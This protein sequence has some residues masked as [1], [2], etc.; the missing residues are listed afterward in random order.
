MHTWHSG[1]VLPL[2]V[3]V[4]CRLC[5]P[6]CS[7][8]NTKQRRSTCYGNTKIVYIIG[9]AYSINFN[10]NQLFYLLSVL[11]GTVALEF[12]H[13]LPFIPLH[14]SYIDVTS[15]PQLTSLYLTLFHFTLLRRILMFFSTH[16]L[17]LIY[18]IPEFFLKSSGLQER[19]L[20]PTAGS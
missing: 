17:H 8:S 7:S 1:F 15:S 12:H 6:E 9:H 3:S 4:S 13:N 14:Y 10:T 5:K 2:F 16:S 18:H 11:F 19:V 20:K